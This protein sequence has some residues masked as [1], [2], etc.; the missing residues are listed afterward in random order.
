MKQQIAILASGPSL[1]EYWFASML[2][3][4]DTVIGVN[5]ATFLFKTRWAVCIDPDMA[6]SHIYGK[7]ING[8]VAIRPDIGYVSTR[9][10]RDRLILTGKQ[11]REFPGQSLGC[12]W[13][14]CNALFFANSLRR[15]KDFQ[16][17]IFGFDCALNEKD[18]NNLYSNHSSDRFERELVWIRAAWLKTNRV[19]SKLSPDV[20]NWLQGKTKTLKL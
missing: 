4:Y 12:N 11:Y 16:I 18:C 2:E 15:E 10:W 20:L 6:E 17:D 8:Q 1:S 3:D 5:S 19:F 7:V 13:S 9:Q 14:F